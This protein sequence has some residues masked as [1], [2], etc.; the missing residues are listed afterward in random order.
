MAHSCGRYCLIRQNNWVFIASA[1]SE[2]MRLWR[3][4]MAPDRT[5]CYI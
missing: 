1:M 3:A 4:A 5:R 2:G